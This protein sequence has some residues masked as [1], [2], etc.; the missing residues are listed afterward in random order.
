MPTGIQYG[1]PRGLYRAYMIDCEII[2]NR[3]RLLRSIRSNLP[4]LFAR[5]TF[6]E[7][8]HYLAFSTDVDGMVSYAKKPADVYDS[9]KRIRTTLARYL[10]RRLH[11]DVNKYQ[12]E[13][14]AISA[15]NGF[16]PNRFAIRKDVKAVYQML[17][18]KG[19]DKNSC[20][21]DNPNDC[22]SFYEKNKIPVLVFEDSARALLW[23]MSNGKRYLDRIYPNEGRHI[24]HYRQWCEKNGV[25][26]RSHQY[27]P[28]GKEY[29]EDLSI[30]LDASGPIPY[31]DSFRYASYDSH[32]CSARFSNRYSSGS[33]VIDWTDGATIEDG[34]EDEGERSHCEEC[35][36]WYYQEDGYYIQEVCICESCYSSGIVFHC[37]RCEESYFT[38]NVDSDTVQR[39]LYSETWC[40]NCLQ[41]AYH[42]DDCGSYFASIS[43]VTETQESETYCEDCIGSNATQCE[44]CGEWTDSPT[45]NNEGE[46]YC[47]NCIHDHQD[48]TSD[49]SETND[50]SER[51]VVNVQE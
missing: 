17:R 38:D 21:R 9:A 13:C 20:M 48:E 39:N 22:L 33:V 51:T 16:N 28:E 41:E 24:P 37:E 36:E 1:R 12:K 19:I 3:V 8:N 26:M 7:E 31:L 11:I 6:D 25:T 14:E 15:V 18:D 40:G 27:L 43:R 42:C 45:E 35:G 30:T 46:S 23:T 49:A 10:S 29:N 47:D 34:P 4:D 32:C 5:I 50:A 2:R 44:E